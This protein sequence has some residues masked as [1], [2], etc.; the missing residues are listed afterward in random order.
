MIGRFLYLI[1][2]SQN[3]MQAM[4]LVARFQAFPHEIHTIVVKIIFKYL[5][6]TKKYG[7]CYARREEFK[8]NSYMDVDWDGNVD[9]RKSTSGE[10][11][12]LGKCLVLWSNKKQASISVSAPEEG[13]IVA[14]TCYMKI[15]WMKKTLKDIQVDLTDP[16]Q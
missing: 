12:F 11:F 13:Y 4:G 8:L 1:A 5:Q 14:T 10:T 6:G 9:D 16:F 3:I 2:P 15:P 7:L